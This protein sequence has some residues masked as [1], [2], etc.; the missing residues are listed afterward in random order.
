MAAGWFTDDAHRKIH[1]LTGGVPRLINQLCEHALM[2]LARGSIERLEGDQMELA[3]SDLQQLPPPRKIFAVGDVE[4]R[5]Q[6]V[7]EHAIEFGELTTTSRLGDGQVS[8]RT[9]EPESD[10]VRFVTDIGSF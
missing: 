10:A 8:R 3:W 9:D 2:M 7:A 5:A 6:T 4:Q 1:E